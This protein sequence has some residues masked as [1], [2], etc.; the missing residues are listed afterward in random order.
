[1]DAP[2]VVASFLVAQQFTYTG[3][4]FNITTFIFPILMAILTW[5]AA[6]YYSRLYADRRYNKFSE[7]IIYIIYTLFLF[8]IFFSAVLFFLK[9]GTV[10]YSPKFFA[11][12]LSS[13]F[14]LLNMVKYITRKYMH[15]LTLRGE[16]YDNVLLIGS[17][18]FALDFYQT[19]Q[20]HPYYGYKCIGVLDSQPLPLNG[21]CP[22]LGQIDNLSNILLE[23]KVD[24]VVI[25]LSNAEHE[26]IKKCI[27]VCDSHKKRVRIVP[28]FYQYASSAFQVNNIG[29]IPTI[30]LG[31]LPLDKAFN[32]FIKRIFDVCFS[33]CF[34]ILIGSWLL[35][36]IA[37]AVKLS[38]KGPV[39]FKQERWGLNNQKIIC[40]KF[41]SMV[42]GSA[43]TDENGK[44][45]QAKKND[46]RVTPIG[47][48]L[49]KT[50]LDELPQFW[51]V[52]MGSMS[53]VGPRP[54]PVPMNIELMHTV[55]NYL[56]RH[57][58]KPGI[59]GWAQVNGSRGATTEQNDIKERITFDLFYI[60]RWTLTFDCQIILQTIITILRGDKNAY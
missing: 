54:H 39:F 50:S 37:I 20:K 13:F 30:N 19:V 52:L 14:V 11:Y 56:R 21:H 5:Y 35:P 17:T 3:T 7:E 60:H 4:G 8:T 59:T 1:M 45:L 36:I 34:F 32:K 24:E 23:S 31:S 58:V 9:A 16:L 6:A 18:P 42:A 51:N 38:S 47:S 22:Y 27:Q 33:T 12:F 10:R 41:R 15:G 28:D 25:T 40:Y 43:D 48:F 26:T 2:L 46:S 44:Y 29:L 55:E 53:I 49:R 57:L